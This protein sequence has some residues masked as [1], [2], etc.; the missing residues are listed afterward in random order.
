MKTRIIWFSAGLVFAAFLF[1]VSFRLAS[2]PRPGDDVREIDLPPVVQNITRTIHLPGP[3]VREELQWTAE[4]FTAKARLEDILRAREPQQRIVYDGSRVMTGRVEKDLPDAVVFTERFGE[5]GEMTVTIPRDR[6]VRIEALDVQIPALSLRDVRFFR[7]FPNLNFYKK[8]PYTLMTEESFFEVERIVQQ[9]RAL[10][11]DFLDIFAPLLQTTDRRD[12]IQILIFS[13][14]D[15]YWRYLAGRAPELAGSFGF[16]DRMRDRL[17]ILH[18]RDA[19][20][21]TAARQE[22]AEIE[23]EHRSLLTTARARSRFARWK[24]DAIGGL[25]AQAAESTRQTIRHEGAH[26]LA[27]TLG[28]QNPRQSGRAWLTEGLAVFFETDLPGEVDPSRSAELKEASAVGSFIPLDGLLAASRLKTPL[29]YAQAGA[30]FGRLMQP[31]LRA[32]FFDYLAWLRDHPLPSVRSP[33]DTLCRFLPL[34]P[35]ALE[36]AWIGRMAQEARNAPAR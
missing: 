24:R 22:I 31:D 16:Y 4:D 32:G 34:T 33:S 13:E 21:M 10:Y 23:K 11:E 17:A 20:W 27:F 29:E 3:P 14:P 36:T 25:A 1:A 5:N 15:A 12:D 7:E 35:A 6:M 8:P 30:L 26:Q 9:Q 28:V 19:D 18:Q 2:L